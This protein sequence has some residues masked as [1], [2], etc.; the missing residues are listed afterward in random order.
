MTTEPCPRCPDGHDDPTRKPWSAWVTTV[1][2]SDG[3]PSTLT[4]APSDGSHVAESDAEW[5][6]EVLRNA[7]REVTQ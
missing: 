3:T 7:R 1:T 6:R 2:R 4:V 5:L